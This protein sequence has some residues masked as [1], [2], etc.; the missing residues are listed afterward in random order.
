MREISHGHEFEQLT[1]NG[2]SPSR[3]LPKC[4]LS[5]HDRDARRVLLIMEPLTTQPEADFG[6]DVSR[7]AKGTARTGDDGSGVLLVLQE[8]VHQKRLEDRENVTLCA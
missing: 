6:L 3:Q 5:E 7:T 1:P 8:T 2:F 4:R